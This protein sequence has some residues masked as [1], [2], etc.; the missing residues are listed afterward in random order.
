MPQTTTKQQTIGQV[1]TVLKRRYDPDAPTER[2][3]L[4]QLLFGVL[5]EGATAD[6]AERAFRNLSERFYDWNEVR[7]SQAAE[8]EAALE[9][10]PDAAGKAPR[11]IGLLQAV[12]EQYFNFQLDEIAKKGLK[13]AI[14][15]LE[16]K[17]PD[18]GGFAVA[19]VVQ[20][21]LGGHALPLDAAALRCLRRLG[22][23][24]S[25]EGLESLRTSLEHHVPKAKGYLFSEG[26]SL[27][28]KD[29]CWE[30]EP[31]CSS[32]ALKSDCP[33]GQ[34]RKNAAPRPPRLKPR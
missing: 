33:T 11:V 15:Q 6:A 22:V 25:E 19:W 31:H 14:K 34:V 1:L 20:Q 24:E 4:E 32:C 5:R 23:A 28:A 26:L 21:A 12:F 17:F 3:V 30:E 8:V 10:L 2:P 18:A 29:V 13:N 9:N 27:L 16:E 7:V